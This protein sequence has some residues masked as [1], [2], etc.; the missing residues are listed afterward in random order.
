MRKNPRDDVH[1]T[2]CRYCSR[3]IYNDSVP[4][5]AAGSPWILS[6]FLDDAHPEGKDSLTPL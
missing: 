2:Y 6:A 5:V 3:D 1:P 4:S